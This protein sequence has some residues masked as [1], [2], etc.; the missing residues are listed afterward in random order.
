MT[1]S[2]DLDVFTDLFDSLTE[3]EEEG[4]LDSTAV[5]KL[6][7]L[8]KRCKELEEFWSKSE[9]KPIE[10][11]FILYHASRNLRLILEKM[12]SRFTSATENKGNP[13][14]IVDALRVTPALN[15]L[16]NTIVF[17]LR[18]PVTGEMRSLISQRTKTLRSISAEASML[19]SF[20]DEIRDASPEMLKKEFKRFAGRIRA[21]FV[22][23]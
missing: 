15:Q 3:M 11:A 4:K 20:E 14:V 18:K 2:S 6:D 1:I 16:F 23:V 5:D 17:N 7:G 22:E 10:D 21:T 13:Q 8:I 19:P 9:E 12:R